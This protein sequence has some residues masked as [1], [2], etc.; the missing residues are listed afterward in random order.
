MATQDYTDYTKPAKSGFPSWLLWVSLALI[1]AIILGTA[2]YLFF[3]KP[4]ITPELTTSAPTPGLTTSAPPP[5]PITSA[6]PAGGI[7]GRYIK[8]Q[9]SRPDCMNIAG[10][11]IYNIN[12][13]LIDN[14]NFL[15]TMSS[16]YP[17][18]WN[19]FPKAI[20]DTNINTIIHT[21]DCA[22]VPWIKIDMI[23]TFN[24]GKVKIC[25]SQYRA[26]EKHSKTRA[27][28]TLCIFFRNMTKNP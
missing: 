11:E 28:T 19:V 13:T 1:F 6:P 27:R 3:T 12:N 5:R 26:E 7:S 22:A 16:E 2:L 24:I 21:N 15:I 14:K 10:V 25:S 23:N 8:I 17:I 4:T 20:F 9:G 18:A